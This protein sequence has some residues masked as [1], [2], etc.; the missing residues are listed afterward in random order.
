MASR[1]DGLSS[2]GF[3]YVWLIHTRCS[4]SEYLSHQLEYRSCC[5]DCSTVATNLAIKHHILTVH[6]SYLIVD[7]ASVQV[8]RGNTAAGQRTSFGTVT[9]KNSSHISLAKVTIQ[10]NKTSFA[11]WA[12][13]HKGSM[14]YRHFS[15]YVRAHHRVDQIQGKD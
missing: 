8:N 6:I 7:S 2:S 4:G 11:R 1:I 9:Y 12:S 13:M 15:Q 5:Y 14:V 3:R 10:T